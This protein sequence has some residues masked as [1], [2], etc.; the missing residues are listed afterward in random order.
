LEPIRSIINGISAHFLEAE[1]TDICFNEKLIELNPVDGSSEPF[2]VPYDKLVI[3]VGSLSIT[4]GIEGIEHCHFLKTINDARKLRK[5]IMDNF[6]KASLPTTSPK[7]RKCL[8]S[9]VV[10]GGGPTGVEFAAELYD[11]LTEDVVKYQ[12]K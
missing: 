7:E 12:K 11:F 5:K 1:A 9:F 2:Y 6:E 10:C 3:A 8:L 4:Y